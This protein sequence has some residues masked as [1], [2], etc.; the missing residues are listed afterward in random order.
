VAGK[1]TTHAGLFTTKLLVTMYFSSQ[2]ALCWRRG[3]EITTSSSP[4]CAGHRLKGNIMRILSQ[5]LPAAAI[6][7]L[8]I[9]VAPTVF[10][11]APPDVTVMEFFHAPTGHYF[12]TGSADDQRALTSAPANL[13]FLAT[14]RSF[15]AWSEN[16]KNRP[17]NA[18]AV[19]RSSTRPPHRTCSPPARP[20]SR[21]CAACRSRAIRKASA[22]KVSPSLR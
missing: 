13:S 21:C 10:A 18:V 1:R 17:A 4:A 16:N 7:A 15:A 3:I 20:T 14:R 6:A 19:Q 11:A 2:P 12:M 5:S 22:M 9:G 8:T